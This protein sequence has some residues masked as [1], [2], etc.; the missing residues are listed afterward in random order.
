[1]A[2]RS[3][4]SD[5]LGRR[6]GRELPSGHA[7]TT[8][9]RTHRARSLNRGLIYCSISGYGA[10]G[11][12]RDL[13][14]YD[15]VIQGESGLMDVTG[16]PGHGADQS[17][18][19]DHRL[20]RGLVRCAGHS[21]GTHRRGPGREKGSSSTSRFSIRPSRCSGCPP[22]LSRRP[23]KS[24]QAGQRASFARTVRAATAL[25]GEVI[26]AVAN[27]RL[28]SRFCEAVGAGPLEHDP[29]FATNS[30][31]LA[32]RSALNDALRELFHDRPW[33]RSSFDSARRVCR[34]AG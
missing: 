26:V 31:R 30:D 29:R 28:W 8:R 23:A 3:S 25:D 22:G 2:R 14:G 15:M 9:L 20:P 7:R 18:C 4:R 11:P 21:A 32:N 24:R 34:A 33:T 5:P 10:T 17:R 13:P 6:A 16:F 19:G 12:R 1:M 27:P